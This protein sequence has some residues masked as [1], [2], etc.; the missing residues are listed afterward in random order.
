[1]IVSN[2][3]ID[4]ICLIDNYK[5]EI[6]NLREMNVGEKID[7][8]DEAISVLT[9]VCLDLENITKKLEVKGKINEP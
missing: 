5:V 8:R 1:M 7:R 2:T 3:Y 4:L 6:R 9:Q